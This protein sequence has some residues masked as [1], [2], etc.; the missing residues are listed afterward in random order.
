MLDIQHDQLSNEQIKSAV[1]TFKVDKDW[2]TGNNVP[3]EKVALYRYTD[4]W[5]KQI[6]WPK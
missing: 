2:M 5:E 3:E 1:I 6:K 4:K